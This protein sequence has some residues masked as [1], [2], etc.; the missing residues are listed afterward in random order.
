MSLYC[1]TQHC[2]SKIQIGFHSVFPA[3]NLQMRGMQLRLC[4]DH[5]AS[6]TKILWSRCCCSEDPSA[7]LATGSF[8]RMGL[9]VFSENRGNGSC[10]AY[11]EV[12]LCPSL[13]KGAIPSLLKLL[14]WEQVLLEQKIAAY[15]LGFQYAIINLPYVLI[16]I[17]FMCELTLNGLSVHYTVYHSV[18]CQLW[19]LVAF[20][21]YGTF[22]N[23][24]TLLLVL[25]REMEHKKFFLLG[26]ICDMSR[27][28]MF[29]CQCNLAKGEGMALEMRTLHH[30]WF[31][32]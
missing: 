5:T 30:F 8:P 15:F 12:Q 4:R 16:N 10:E 28:R 29:K 19:C 25:E 32:F 9:R 7:Y 18:P 21:I 13:T 22:P 26:I 2:C 6:E 23:F 1:V 17:S 20:G 14:E 31:S 27:R 3:G 24:L 11:A